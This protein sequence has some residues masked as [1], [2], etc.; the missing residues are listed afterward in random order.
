MSVLTRIPLWGNASQAADHSHRRRGNSC[1]ALLPR[2]LCSSAL[3]RLIS[4]GTVCVISLLGLFAWSLSVERRQDEPFVPL[5]ELA[6]LGPL[7]HV[8]GQLQTDAGPPPLVGELAGERNAAAPFVTPGPAAMPFRFASNIGDRARARACLAAAMF[9]EAGDDG[10]GQLAVG[11]V[12]LNRT[13][14]PA[15]PAS[16]CGVVMQGSGRTTGCQFTFTCDGALARRP[17][18]GAKA[19][20]L[21]HADLMLDGLVFAAV[22]LATHYHTDAVYPWWSSK[23]DKVA[24]VGT[25]LF[26]RWPGFWGSPAAIARRRSVPEPPAV[27]FERFA[28]GD[29]PVPDLPELPRSGHS[30]ADAPPTTAQQLVR[31]KR[32]DEDAVYP[33]GS[34]AIPISRR[35]AATAVE[36]GGDPVV[37]APVLEGNRLLRMFPQESVFHLQLTGAPSERSRRRVAEMLCGGRPECRVYGWNHAADAPRSPDPN[38]NARRAP[39]FTYVRGASSRPRTHVSA[40][41]A[42]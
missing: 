30:Q 27:M 40:V 38:L 24:R 10:I 39:A 4:G 41:G 9:Y 31:E 12:V 6:R 5:A 23:L 28:G 16:V 19:R 42:M 25:H 3:S 29:A 22:G 21:M 20:A 17:S 15:F 35:L 8:P 1:A 33:I 14:H 36:G 37:G 2:I 7:A 13:R 32:P 11:Q 34:A 18:P 26:L